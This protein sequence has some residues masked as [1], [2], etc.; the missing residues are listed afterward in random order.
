M[1]TLTIRNRA[2]TVTEMMA[3]IREKYP[4]TLMVDDDGLMFVVQ[5]DNELHFISSIHIVNFKDGKSGIA[6]HWIGLCGPDE[7]WVT[8]LAQ[9]DDLFIE[10]Y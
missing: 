2:L 6:F 1:T 8:G 3:F 10:V 7:A 5:R 9:D 4:D